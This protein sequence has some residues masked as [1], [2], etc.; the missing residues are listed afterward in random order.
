MLL[1]QMGLMSY[2]EKKEIRDDGIRR[3]KYYSLTQKGIE[4][5]RHIQAMTHLLVH[6]HLPEAA[7]P[8]VRIGA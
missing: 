4:V 3:V 1:V 8:I 6:E 5:A 2:N 7:R